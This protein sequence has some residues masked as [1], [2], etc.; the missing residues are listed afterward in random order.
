MR[1]LRT[2]A[3]RM[4]AA[5]LVLE[6]LETLRDPSARADA[7]APTVRRLAGRNAWLPDDPELLARVQGAA[8]VAG[9]ALLATGRAPRVACALLAAQSVPTL[10]AHLREFRDG[11]P[12]TR[13]ALRRTAVRDLS[14]LG[15]LVLAA[16]EPR[17]RP[18]VPGDRGASTRLPRRT[19]ART[20]LPGIRFR[21]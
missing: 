11:T 16:T 19:P 17:H 18:S 15:A 20:A 14:L 2:Q 21:R 1:L 6:G 8:G 7:L 3:R 13:G 10:V 9:G 12:E 4:L 5:P